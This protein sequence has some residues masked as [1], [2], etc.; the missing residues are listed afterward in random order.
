MMRKQEGERTVIDSDEREQCKVKEK[1]GDD[2]SND[3]RVPKRSP[4]AGW[5]GTG[6][7]VNSRGISPPHKAGEENHLRYPIITV[8]SNED[9]RHTS[10]HIVNALSPSA[11][12]VSD[13]YLVA[14]SS[15]VSRQNL[16]GAGWEIL[17]ITW[18][19]KASNCS[20]D[21]HH[22]RTNQ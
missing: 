10:M 19:S 4:D 16:R 12:F 8:S 15:K 1:Q 17:L 13:Q 21:Q 20:R 6:N 14:N 7:T 9:T 3:S 5:S 2:S 11:M 22:A 18:P